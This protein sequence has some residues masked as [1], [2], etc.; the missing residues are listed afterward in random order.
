MA[1]FKD[2]S[3]ACQSVTL[4][5]GNFSK[6]NLHGQDPSPVWGPP[7]PHAERENLTWWACLDARP[8]NCFFPST[9]CWSWWKTRACCY[10]INDSGVLSSAS[11]ELTYA[12]CEEPYITHSVS[13]HGCFSVNSARTNFTV[14]KQL[15]VPKECVMSCHEIWSFPVYKEKTC[16]SLGL[17]RN[18]FSI[19]PTTQALG[20]AGTVQHR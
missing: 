20:R 18:N 6:A 8:E 13:S 17:I 16:S 5:P 19:K 11:K 14:L 2:F 9:T 15:M 4:A 3:T 1:N 7:R 12:E 10:F